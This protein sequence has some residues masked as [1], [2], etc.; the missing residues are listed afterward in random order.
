MTVLPRIPHK[1]YQKSEN[2]KKISL[3][4]VALIAALN[5]YIAWFEMFAWTTRG[6]KVFDTFP[7]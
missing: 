7:P 6:P 2:M 4:F 3:S 5:V 1:I